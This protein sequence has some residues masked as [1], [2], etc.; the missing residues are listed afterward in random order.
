MANEDIGRPITAVE[1]KRVLSEA[2]RRWFQK[3][4]ATFGM[5]QAVHIGVCG[6]RI[7]LGSVAPLNIVASLNKDEPFL[8]RARNNITVFLPVLYQ[9]GV[10][11]A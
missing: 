3:G 9:H 8:D 2:V 7:V 6:L 4:L 1:I 11:R 5:L 10:V